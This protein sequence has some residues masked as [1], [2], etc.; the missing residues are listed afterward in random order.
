MVELMAF[1]RR[2]GVV[3]LAV[4]SIT[5]AL[6]FYRLGSAPMVVGGDEAYFA[7]HAHAIATTGRDLD[8]RFLPL[9]FRIDIHTWYQ[10][11][12]VYLMAA[13][14]ALVDVSETAMRAPTAVIGVVDVALAYAVALRLL[15]RRRDAVIAAGALALAPAHFLFARQGLDYIAPLPFVL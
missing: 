6:Y 15:G 3:M 2:A 10:P 13:V 7:T 9:F 1:A 11:L 5:A 14:F 8:G 4:G 12:L